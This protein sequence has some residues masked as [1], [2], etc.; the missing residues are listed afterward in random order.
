MTAEQLYET[1]NVLYSTTHNDRPE[2]RQSAI[3]ILKQELNR[4]VKPE[5]II[6]RMKQMNQMRQDESKGKLYSAVLG[7]F[8]K[9]EF[10]QPIPYR[11][12]QDD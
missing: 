10:I 7:K 1:L 6:Q 3:E 12:F 8:W 2:E 5:F 4:G 11:K 9:R